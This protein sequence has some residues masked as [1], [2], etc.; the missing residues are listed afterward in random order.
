MKTI[1]RQLKHWRKKRDA[2]R[3]GQEQKAQQ[4]IQ[5]QWR[6]FKVILPLFTHR[7]GLDLY[8]ENS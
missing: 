7:T 5:I 2:V 1:S 8:E 4:G 6:I 3:S